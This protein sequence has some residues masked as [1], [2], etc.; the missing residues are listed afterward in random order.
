MQ[1]RRPKRARREG[2]REAHVR[3][4]PP[5][6]KLP[7]RRA[8]P[9]RPTAPRRAAGPRACGCCATSPAPRGGLRAHGRW[10]RSSPTTR[11]AAGWPPSSGSCSRS[12]GAPSGRRSRP[13]PSRPSESLRV[14]PPRRGA[15]RALPPASPVR[16]R[17]PVRSSSVSPSRLRDLSLW[18]PSRARAAPRRGAWD[19]DSLPA[20]REDAAACACG[21]PPAA[22]GGGGDGGGGDDDDDG[23]LRDGDAVLRRLE[24]YSRG[25][26]HAVSLERE[27]CKSEREKQEWGREQE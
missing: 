3:P 13:R 1:H 21:K 19:T 27:I 5:L 11:P 25:I 24:D 7:P 22:G 14:A 2:R 6:P 16:I 18:R 26:A 23:P 4:P 8:S 12:P 20:G 17:P 15:S 9:P 10:A